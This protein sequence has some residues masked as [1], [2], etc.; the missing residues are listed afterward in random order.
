LLQNQWPRSRSGP[1]TLYFWV[2]W[3]RIYYSLF[4]IWTEILTLSALLQY[5]GR[6]PPPPRDYSIL[7]IN[8]C[9]HKKLVKSSFFNSNGGYCKMVFV[10]NRSRHVY[11]CPQAHLHNLKEHFCKFHIGYFLKKCCSEAIFSISPRLQ[12]CNN[13]LKKCCAAKRSTHIHMSVICIAVID[14]RS[15]DTKKLRNFISTAPKDRTLR[16]GI[17]LRPSTCLV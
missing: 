13:L 2:S 16:L 4:C 1:R 5:V 14:C 11:T 7:R 15:V 6:P 3:I 10:N 9:T 17:V 12:V 8:I